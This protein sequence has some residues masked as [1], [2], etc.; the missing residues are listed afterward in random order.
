MKKVV[1]VFLVLL[2]A[3]SSFSI[4]AYAQN[5]LLGS[6]EDTLP[7][8]TVIESGKTYY[9]STV[10]DLK[11]LAK[12]VNEDGNDCDGVS[13]WLN[14]DIVV[15]SGD[16]SMSD[17]G[18]PLY[19]GKPVEECAELV[20][21]ESIGT[22]K[23]KFK[24]SFIG[25]GHTISGL[26][27]NA[28]FG[29]CSKVKITDFC[30]ENSYI[31][32]KGILGNYF[33]SSGHIR[34]C[35]VEGIVDSSTDK[36]GIFA[37]TMLGTII[38]EC[39]AEGY[40]SGNSNVG[41]FAGNMSNCE[42]SDSMSNVQV[43]ANNT[44]GG[45]A[46]KIYGEDS[47]FEL[48][49]ATGTVNCE[50]ETAGQF[51]S[52]VESY[53]IDDGYE[54][55]KTLNI[56]YATVDSAK[57]TLPFCAEFI[58]EAESVNQCYYMSDKQGENG[59]KT[60]TQKEMKTSAF[61]DVLNADIIAQHEG[62]NLDWGYFGIYFVGN[63]GEYPVPYILHEKGI[64]VS[65]HDFTEWNL[66]N[67][68]NEKRSCKYY[69]CDEYETRTHYH[70]WSEYIYNNDAAED[71]DGTKTAHCLM[72]G[73]T[74]TD[75]IADREHIRTNAI[76]LT[77]N[78]TLEKGKLYT[79][80][81]FNEWKSFV[82]V[83]EQDTTDVS[84]ALKSDI[85]IEK[86]AELK[87]IEKFSGILD[88]MGYEITNTAE[89]FALCDGAEIKN[90]TVSCDSVTDISS[91]SEAAGTL[92]AK[93]INSKFADCTTDCPISG[94]NQYLGGLIGLAENCE[95]I[96][97]RNI[98]DIT[99]AVKC[100]VGGLIGTARNCIIEESYNSGNIYGSTAGGLLGELDECEARYCYNIGDVKGT[101]WSG[102]FAGMIF[103]LDT[104][105][106]I[107]CCYSAGNV[108]GENSGSFCGV[109]S[110]SNIFAMFSCL[111]IGDSIYEAD[112]EGA[113][114]TSFQDYLDSLQDDGY[115]YQIYEG[116]SLGISAAKEE[117][118]QKTSSSYYAS[119]FVGDADNSNKGFI[120]LRRFHTEHVWSEYADNDNGVATASCLCQ[121]CYATKTQKNEINAA[122]CLR[123]IRGTSSLKK[124]EHGEE[125]I[126]INI[127]EGKN[128]AGIYKKM[129]GDEFTDYTLAIENGK[130]IETLTSYVAY[131]SQNTANV[132]G[133][134]VF[135]RSDG[136]TQ[137]YDIVFNLGLKEP[138][139]A[140][141]LRTIRSSASMEIDKNGDEYISVNIADGKNAVG[142]YKDVFGDKFVDYEIT[143]E[144]GKLLERADSY[145]AYVSQNKANI[146]GTITFSIA[147]G[148]TKAY[149]IVFNLGLGEPT[150]EVPEI[151]IENEL[152]LI[153]GSAS[154]SE[155][156]K[157][158]TVTLASGKTA[159]GVYAT[160]KSGYTVEIVSDSATFASRTDAY[161]A[162]VS[163]N[164][165]NVEGIM[166]VTLADGSK[167]EYSVIYD[168]GK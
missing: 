49:A 109:Y 112:S 89:I 23:N 81:N 24:G 158:V 15:N 108:S 143:T 163:Q 130:V 101:T 126:S 22:N 47:F 60:Y 70:L 80:S 73:C 114:Y 133:T 57:G 91:V 29:Y 72:D 7:A 76:P 121:N 17:S 148:T 102:G 137:K 153:R 123:V 97:C 65:A 74:T 83:C 67:S 100:F 93:A 134:I 111:F 127:K 33:S 105:D 19:N 44:A 87:P 150:E 62:A 25:D 26:Y 131:V 13:F 40:V 30:I 117:K 162:Y 165:T 122:D 103:P 48:C 18:E 151:D 31:T 145:V 146:Y 36:V 84:F 125:Y 42:V 98:S 2:M 38:R 53:I 106:T 139:D 75:T 58:G 159:T 166:T 3:F 34:N 14:N 132:R 168:I 37:G 107:Y 78:T 155:D 61:V 28:L 35:C 55:T 52:L 6:T 46:G 79:I 118:L 161:V 138:T 43:K 5:N 27:N 124:D 54:I 59:F 96:G 21:I 94:T 152:R 12:I 20:S 129:L 45:F 135:K 1:S 128:A 88:G 68:A 92:C 56:C 120:Q 136:T 69:A 104:D 41:G 39:Y 147:D 140:N 51:A 66:Y 63:N 164:K 149:K 110:T 167:L 154:L 142:I 16:F 160:T 86:D 90:I 11:T 115:N 141:C 50:D 99:G 95:I 77:E 32:S 71:I 4:G 144:N 113:I 10:E 9:I 82:K 156:G 157:I 85:A 116:K 64:G 8:D 119:K